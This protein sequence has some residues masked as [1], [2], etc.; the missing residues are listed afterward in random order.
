MGKGQ[1]TE[2]KPAAVPE[3]AKQAG[4]ITAQKASIEP[5]YWTE[6]ML[7]TLNKGESRQMDKF[8]GNMKVG[9]KHT[10]PSKGVFLVA[11]MQWTVNP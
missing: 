5:A 4:E 6:H 2:N 7:T 10:L 9:Q 3:R 8:N 11:P 1:M